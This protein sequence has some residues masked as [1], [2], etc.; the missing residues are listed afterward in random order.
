MKK[1]VAISGSLR[2]E[3]YNTKLLK[4]LNDLVSDEFVAHAL[5]EH[6]H[7]EILLL[8]YFGRGH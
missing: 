2:K 4:K 6:K 3:S 8:E 7:L 5:Q 1:I